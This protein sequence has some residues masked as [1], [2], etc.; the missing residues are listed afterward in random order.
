M[1]Y[2]NMYLVHREHCRELQA[3]RIPGLPT[4]LSAS[5]DTRTWYFT[6]SG[7]NVLTSPLLAARSSFSLVAP[8]NAVLAY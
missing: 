6:A 8:R 5:L 1:T 3:S 4:A 7:F 2:C